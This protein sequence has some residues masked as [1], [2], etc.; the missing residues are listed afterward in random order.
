MT[1]ATTDALAV[2]M[3]GGS[4]ERF[5]PLSRRHRPKQ[6]LTLSESGGSLLEQ[7]VARARRVFPPER[8]F[9]ATTAALRSAIVDARLGVPPENVLAEPDR[10]NTAGALIFV[11][12]ALRARLGQGADPVLAVLTA[13][14]H[15]GQPERFAATLSACLAEAAT[16][17][18]LVVIGIPPSRPETG[19]GY[20][21]LDEAK[22]AVAVREGLPVLPVVRFREKP[23]AATAE[24]FVASGR[25]LWNSGMFFWRLSR[26]ISELAAAAPE[27][28]EIAAALAASLARG[29]ESQAVELFRRLPD[30]SI[31]HALM[32]RAQCVRL[33]RG[34]FP[35]DDVGAWDALMRS[36]AHDPDGNVAVG[37]PVLVG[38]RDCLVYNDA[39]ERIAVCAVGVSELA[40][41]VT[42][43]AVLVTPKARAQEVREA[44]RRLRQRDAPQL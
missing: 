30:I 14:H 31:D 17:E 33:V 9:I 35:W 32:E 37:D 24:A 15:I 1:H 18:S 22:G 34:T 5:W 27:L 11:A 25:F 19:Y 39:G 12:A 28:A 41:I 16:G 3:A 36:F 4:G 23:D 7:A 20:L 38:A 21:E 10:R 43:D 29:D 42:D 26:F 44:V 40:I 6:L 2:I 13:D 8:T